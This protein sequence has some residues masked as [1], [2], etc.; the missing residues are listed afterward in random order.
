MPA[1]FLPRI[2][3]LVRDS[4]P[5]PSSEDGPAEIA[6][7][8][9]ECPDCKTVYIDDEMQSCPECAIRVVQVPKELSRNRDNC[10]QN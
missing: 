5:D 1:G 3:R 2:K 9:Y 8:L 4:L 6:A 7:Q 10:I